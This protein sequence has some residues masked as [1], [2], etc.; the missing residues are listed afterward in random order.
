MQEV[1]LLSSKELEKLEGRELLKE[2]K[3][4]ATTHCAQ[5]EQLIVEL[6]EKAKSYDGEIESSTES[7]MQFV[8]EV[9]ELEQKLHDNEQLLATFADNLEEQ[10]ENLK[11]DYIELLNQ[12]AS[13]RNELS[14]IEEQSKQQTSKNERLDE[15]N[16]KYVEMRMEI[17]AKRRNL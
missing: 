2:R 9:K 12:Q 3:Q 14:M 16:A 13:H 7:L 15:E 1:L 4:N 17:T 5:L 10:I 6:T 8:N 11:G